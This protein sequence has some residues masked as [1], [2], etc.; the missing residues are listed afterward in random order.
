VGALGFIDIASDW[1]MPRHDE[2]FGR[3]LGT[4]GVGTGAY[5]VL[6]LLRPSNVRD[7]A[8]LPVNSFGNPVGHVADIPVRNTMTV[9]SAVD[10]RAA[11]LD[12]TELVDRISLDKY[13][14]VR[15]AH[16]QRRRM[17]QP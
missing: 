6:P 16:L 13:L 15:D 4:W 9:L 17:E 11:M 7:L 8:A 10:K 1:G 2:D 12:V 14:F 5:V 3:T